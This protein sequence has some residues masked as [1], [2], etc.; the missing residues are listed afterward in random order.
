MILA[1][2]LIIAALT[3]ICDWFAVLFLRVV[4]YFKIQVV[5]G[6]RRI[7][8]R[9]EKQIANVCPQNQIF[10]TEIL[11]AMLISLHTTEIKS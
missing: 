1:C 9:L 3:L 2:T 4:I 11:Q 8:L 5:D 10:N 7:I 6:Q